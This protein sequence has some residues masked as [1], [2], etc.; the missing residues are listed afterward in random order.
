MK[1]SI[2]EVILKLPWPMTK[3]ITDLSD[4]LKSPKLCIENRRQIR[5][6][7]REHQT[8]WETADH[9]M[10][11]RDIK[12]WEKGLLYYAISSPRAA[13]KIADNFCRCRLQCTKEAE[14]LSKGNGSA[15]DPVFICV[16]KN[17]LERIKLSFEHHKKIGVKQFVYIDNGSTDGTL[18]WLMEQNV[19]IYQV[20]A[21]FIM[22]S[23]VAWISKVVNRIGFERWYLIL[24]SDELFV[25]P[26]CEDHKITEYI[27]YLTKEKCN[28]ALSFMLDMYAKGNLFSGASK[29][30]DILTEFCYFDTDSYTQKNC[31]HYR[32][33]VGG[34]RE[35][36]FANENSME[37]LQNKYALV[38]LKRGEIYRFH[39]VS[40]YKE[41]FGLECT[42]ALLH[43]KFIDGDYE[44][45]VSIAKEGN[46]ANGSRLYKDIVR[47]L[48]EN[49]GDMTF[50]GER[51][52]EYN[53]SYDLL[54]NPL[55]HEWSK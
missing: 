7:F 17:D 34:P 52:A 28:R 44:K 8:I 49:A 55:V 13:R 53:N 50:Y 42:S 11:A 54:K 24:D 21:P 27:S 20:L 29:A 1:K 48:E 12:T 9:Q 40:P 5:K 51:S 32:K 16:V 43:Y 3:F 22:W 10:N 31:M 15:A 30:S 14:W 18:E 23:K 33:I 26:G 36:L 35:R 39:Y 37:M 46:Y 47:V 19:T 2:Y 38:F 4:F 45:Y 41:N 25:Y 6:L